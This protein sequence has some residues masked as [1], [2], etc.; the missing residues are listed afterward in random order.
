MFPT[1]TYKKYLET[2]SCGRGFL[3]RI[4]FLRGTFGPPSGLPNKF[5]LSGIIDVV[6]HS[7]VWHR[8]CETK[9]CAKQHCMTPAISH[10]RTRIV[11]VY[12]A[13]QEDVLL[14]G[15]LRTP[16]RFHVEHCMTFILEPLYDTSWR[17]NVWHHKPNG[18]KGR[19]IG[20]PVINVYY[21]GILFIKS[22]N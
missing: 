12:D 14:A 3:L 20:R 18:M 15:V 8:P 9:S 21:E 10:T 11:Y 17:R 22:R 4:T 1:R 6:W 2:L 16:F 13:G 19:P 5:N 7:D